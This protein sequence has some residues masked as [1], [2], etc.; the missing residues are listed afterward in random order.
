MHTPGHSPGSISLVGKEI[1]ITGDT[2]FAGSI[3]RTDLPGSSE[4][5]MKFSLK[6][7]ATLPDNL[8][9]Y[10]GHGPATTIGEEKRG[11]PFLQII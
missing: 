8:V 1:A 6:K 3:G 9:A 11:N 10:P 2:L 4:H 5:D 7:L